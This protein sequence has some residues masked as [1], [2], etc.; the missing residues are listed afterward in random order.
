MNQSCIK[1]IFA[2]L[3]HSFSL[4]RDPSVLSKISEAI[5]NIDESVSLDDNASDKTNPWAICTETV[6]RENEGKYE[7]CVQQV[8]KQKKSK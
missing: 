6:G 5:K 8:K 4:I 3:Q 7:R 2:T 1:D